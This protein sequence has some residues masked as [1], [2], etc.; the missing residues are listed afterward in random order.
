MNVE[1]GNEAGQGGD[2]WS[3]PRMPLRDVSRLKEPQ[4]YETIRNRLVGE[5]LA[6]RHHALLKVRGVFVSIV[7]L[8]ANPT[9]EDP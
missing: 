6:K 3:A 7:S 5:R 8:P 9:G 1:K 2:N 4:S